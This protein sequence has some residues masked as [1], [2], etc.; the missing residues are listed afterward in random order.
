MPIWIEKD[1]GLAD[2]AQD[3]QKFVD[4]FTVLGSPREMMMVA[5]GPVHKAQIF[6]SLLDRKYLSLFDGYTEV[7]E[8][9]LPRAARGLVSH[10]DEF[11]KRF[12]YLVDL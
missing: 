10:Q 6:V 4:L 11:E 2:Y 9:D 7:S 12:E 3:Q 5:T 8:A 1:F